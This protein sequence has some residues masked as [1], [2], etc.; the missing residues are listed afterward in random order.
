MRKAVESIIAVVKDA[1]RKPLSTI[2]ADLYWLFR[3]HP[4]KSIRHYFTSLIYKKNSG[5]IE[6][7]IDVKTYLQIGKY[8]L[9][10]NLESTPMLEDKIRFSEAM[11]SAGYETSFYLGKI[12]SG[13]FCD[14]NQNIYSL[15]NSSTKTKFEELVEIHGSIFIKQVDLYGGK[16]VYKINAEDNI[17]MSLFNNGRRFIVE[18]ALVQHD[19][20]NRINSYCIN[21][22]RCVTYNNGHS[23]QVVACLF[24]MGVNKS[25]KD[26]ASAGGIFVGYDIFKNELSKVAYRLF[27]KGGTSFYTHPDSGF[28]FDKSPLPYPSEVIRLVTEA[29]ML[30]PDKDI[31]GWDIAYTPEGPVVLEANANPHVGMTQIVLKG[32][33]NSKVYRDI[34]SSLPT[35]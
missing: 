16:G 6:D 12:E 18:K 7:Y 13:A 9:N 31:I 24:R 26:N 3:N 33:K 10:H 25:F 8:Q 23:P 28:I 4:D 20:L 1:D 14:V 29:A 19:D 2:I 11:M 34:I 15:E 32:L 22:L 21:T 17:N 5:K 35:D 27:D 30:F